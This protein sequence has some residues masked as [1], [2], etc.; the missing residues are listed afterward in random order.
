[1]HLKSKQ[2]D[3]IVN[4]LRTGHTSTNVILILV[5]LGIVLWE[6]YQGRELGM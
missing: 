1:M 6:G 2:W 4:C 5:S 3:P